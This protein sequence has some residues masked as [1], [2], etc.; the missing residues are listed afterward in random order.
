[1]FRK[2]LRID[3]LSKRIPAYKLSVIAI[4]VSLASL[5][6]IDWPLVEQAVAQDSGI[7]MVVGRRGGIDSAA[8]MPTVF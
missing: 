7:Q 6:T 3:F 5:L 8:D 1:M 4:L 2:P